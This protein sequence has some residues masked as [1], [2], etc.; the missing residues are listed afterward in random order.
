MHYVLVAASLLVGGCGFVVPLPVV[1]SEVV[2][3][4]HVYP[5][6]SA[7]GFLERVTARARSWDR[8]ATLC[9]IEGID[10][11]HDGV[12]MLSADSF[13]TYH[14]RARGRAGTLM[15]EIRRSGAMR[16]VEVE[17][18]GP[19]DRAMARTWMVDSPQVLRLAHAH[20]MPRSG[21]FHM[22]LREDGWWT[23]GFWEGVSWRA[24]RI[25]AE[26]GRV[27]ERRP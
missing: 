21:D 10:I 4:A 23:V 13:W 18:V 27:E 8:G 24:L 16:A 6:G 7:K 19:T 11:G 15:V 5:F 26:T 12:L 9:L 22:L 2:Q 17:P 14:F 25:D 1:G 20:G 3:A